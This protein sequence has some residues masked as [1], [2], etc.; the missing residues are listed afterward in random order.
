MM[1]KDINIQ[2]I[3]LILNY[4]TLNYVLN[5]YKISLT[6]LISSKL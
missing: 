4:K 3:K 1:I 2:I 5:T 6:L